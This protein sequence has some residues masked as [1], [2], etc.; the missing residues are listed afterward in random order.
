MQTDGRADRRIERVVIVGG[1]SAGWMVAAALSKL[2]E[3]TRQ[4]HLVESEE[5]GTV[6]VGEAT[7]PQ[8]R[9]FNSALEIDED[10]FVRQ[11]QGTFKL[12]IEFVNWGAIGDRYMHTFGA[13]GQDL[14]MVAFHH[15]WMKANLA[16]AGDGL[17]RFAI[18]TVA[19]YAGKFSREVNA[20]GLPPHRMAYAYHFD[21]G[22]Y[23]R[24]LR[25]YSEERGVIRH[26]GKIVSVEQ[27]PTDEFVSALVL[28]DGRRIEGDLF[29][30]C[31]G[32][33]GLLI[34]ETL[35]TGYEDWTH[36][37]PCDRAVAVPCMNGGQPTPYTR[38]TARSAGW[39]WR[40]PLQHRIGNGHVYSSKFISD[41]E[42]TSQLMSSLDG[43]ALAEPRRLRF[44]TGKR[45]KL[46]NKNVVAVGLASGFLE[47]LES[48]SLY[49]VQSSISRLIQFFPTLDFD[50][51]SIDEH[52]RQADEEFER[53]R[54]FIILHYHVTTRQD[55]PFWSYVQGMDVP[56]SLQNKISLFR[57]SGRLFRAHLDI[58][59]EV[60]WLQV[61]TGQRL[62]PKSH[63]PLA[64]Q[65]T[66][67]ELAYF[68]SNIKAGI[69]RY[70]DAM[71]SHA[72]FI[73]K[74]CASR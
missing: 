21:A 2:L 4:I 66:D 64:D 45:R 43:R 1:G 54:D 44:T 37:L 8:M 47:P 5:I 3:G 28:H 19:S 62:W 16:R 6:G 71:P 68:L 65:L 35:R 36:W 41:D 73:A 15:Y 24:Y 39:Q 70:V 17:E 56:Q 30:D 52:N 49:L 40:I 69:D 29:V 33:R 13:V 11:T 7:I 55:T 60:S 31:S 12:G 20:P 61:M 72:E 74:N 63:H 58:F 59:T 42:A 32:F 23:A 38:A 46:W 51:Q 53:I 67:E 34:E 18:N 26:E 48:T 57:E 25:G 27:R 50:S 14:G 10:E 9:L 22:L